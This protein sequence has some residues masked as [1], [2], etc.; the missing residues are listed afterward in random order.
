MLADTKNDFLTELCEHHVSGQ[1]KVA[2]EH[3]SP[4]VLAVMGK[5]SRKTYDRFTAAYAAVNKKRAVAS[6][7]LSF[8]RGKHVLSHATVAG[9]DAEILELEAI[10]SSSITKAPLRELKIPNGILIGAIRGPRGVEVATGNSIVKPGDRVIV[11]GL[12]G[13]IDQILGLFG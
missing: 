13:T 2:P 4:D 12:P 11:F 7:V 10:E 8:L 3:V 6:E 1:L 9:L 5:P